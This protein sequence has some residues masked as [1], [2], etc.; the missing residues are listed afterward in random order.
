MERFTIF[1]SKTFL[2]T[3]PLLIL[4][5]TVVI[6]WAFSRLW[7]KRGGYFLA[8]VF[9]WLV[10][11]LFLPFSILDGEEIR[12]LFLNLSDPFER[13][14]VLEGVLLMLPPFLAGITVFRAKITRASGKILWFSAGLALVNGTLEE[15]LW[16]GTFITFFP[17][18]WF[19]GFIYPT[20]GFALWHL[21]P[22]VVHPGQ[23]PGGR[24][25]FLPGAFFLGLCWGWTAWQTQSIVLTVFSH[26]L[27]DFLG[28][29]GFVYV[30]AQQ[31][32]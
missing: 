20:I 8:F 17:S 19:W 21:A 14:T 31:H 5:S 32:Q 12:H 29:G 4:I 30:N 6:F 10:W 1:T 18:H 2:L 24:K 25:T 26:V 15:L 13:L 11:G 23:M 22:Q 7:G 28:L 27:T 9:Y 16:R 3:T